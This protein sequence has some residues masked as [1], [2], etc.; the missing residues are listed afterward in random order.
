MTG[1][2][3]SIGNRELLD[4]AVPEVSAS[5]RLFGGTAAYVTRTPW[6][7]WLGAL[8]TLL[9][10]GT[11][12]LAGGALGSPMG[13]RWR[14]ESL[15]NLE[16]FILGAWQVLVVVL[17]L[18]LSALGGG[19]ISQVLALERP[20][21]APWV[22][23]VALLLLA[24]INV[25]VSIVQYF[26]FPS[27][28]YTDLRPFVGFMTGSDWL[29]ALLV[30][31]VG[32]PLSEELL[33]RGFLLSALSRSRLGFLGAALI[34]TAAWTALHASYTAFGIAEVFM[35]GLFFCWLLWRT[36]SLRVAIFCHALYN[37]MIVLV[38]RY[39]PLPT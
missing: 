27:D 36:G 8:A 37:S 6:G 39:V 31:G 15:Q 35:I 24:A 1:C 25:I 17:T 28:M 22:Y 7:P 11:A 20:R 23:L 33:F 32:A 21:G 19:R 10:I 9:V 2:G 29:W 26:L 34:S 30:V 18:V 3:R 38:L 16:L 13:A 12:I 4:L 14:P 5:G